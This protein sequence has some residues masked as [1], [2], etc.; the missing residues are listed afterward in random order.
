MGGRKERKENR[1]GAVGGGLPYQVLGTVDASHSTRGSCTGV[2]TEQAGQRRENYVR[3]LS[4]S[5]RIKKVVVSTK[6]IKEMYAGI[7]EYVR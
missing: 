5:L 7:H 2:P 6:A 4:S 3:C 1:R